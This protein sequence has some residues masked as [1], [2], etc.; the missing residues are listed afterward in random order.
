MLDASLL[1]DARQLKVAGDINAV[2][3]MG[4]EGVKLKHFGA[5]LVH[6]VNSP[7]AVGIGALAVGDIKYQLQNR[8]LA[9]MLATDKP[10]YLDFRHAFERARELV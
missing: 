10:V 5:P 2:P 4:I 8:L 9:L 1:A 7:N 6:A 3:P